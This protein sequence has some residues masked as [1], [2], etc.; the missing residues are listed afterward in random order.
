MGV[1]EMT[2]VDLSE[3]SERGA[4][5]QKRRLNDGLGE[6]KRGRQGGRNAVYL[7][8]AAARLLSLF[9]CLPSRMH[10]RPTV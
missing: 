1:M 10:A 2:P 9:H 6:G 3:M 4:D 8:T 5:S 7:S